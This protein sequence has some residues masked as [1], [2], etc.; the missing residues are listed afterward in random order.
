MNFWLSGGLMKRLV[1][2]K[3][4]LMTIFI[5]F[6]FII[7]IVTFKWLGLDFLPNFLFIDFLIVLMLSSVALLFKSNRLSK[8]YLTLL[9]LVFLVIS[10]TNQ[11]MKIELNG[12]IF[13]LSH[14]KYVDEATNVFLIEFIH[15]DALTVLI[16]I[17][18]VYGITIH[19]VSKLFFRSYL[20]EKQYYKQAVTYFSLIL[21]LF[22]TFFNVGI[23]SFNDYG[24]IFNI[25]LFKRETI[26]EYGLIGFYY[27]DVDILV[28]N[29]GIDKYN[30]E[31]LE[32]SLVYQ[33]GDFYGDSNLEISYNGLLEGKNVITIMVESGQSFAINEFLTPTLYKM[34]TQ[35]LFFPNHYSENKTNVSEVIG[36]LG[37]YPS[38]GI[39]PNRYDYDFQYSLPNILKE[40]GYH[41]AYFH[42][43]V[44]SFYDR[45]DMMPA[46]GFDDVYLHDTL[47]PDEPIYGWG[48]DYTLDSRTM[49][50][51]FDFM[52]DDDEPFYYFWSTLVGH[53]P[54][55]LN[56]P[57]SRG[58]NNLRKFEN[59]GYFTMIDLAESRGDWTNLMKDS[60]NELD[61]GRYKFYQATM[62]DFDRAMGKLLNQ[63]EDNDLLEDTVI[64]IYGDHSL[65]YHQMN[66]RLNDV[67]KG[68]IH[69]TEMYKTMFMVYNPILTSAYLTN[70]NTT[71]TT[72][73]KLV[74][75]YDILPT[76]FHLLGLPHYKNFVL[77]ESVLS[78]ESTIFYSHKMSA[79]FNE[80]YFSFN[81]YSIFYPEDILINEDLDA[82]NFVLKTRDL[83]E[84]ILWLEL[85]TELSKTKK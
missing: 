43:N 35:G 80:D 82:L 56:Y 27:K 60:E 31:E 25:N 22:F 13:S 51:M 74:T 83:S 11:T 2:E 19:Y 17:A 8:T 46:L 75:P 65:Y 72:I 42:E 49:D 16:S 69:H 15:F 41:T 64:I 37:S 59:L 14:F 61:P 28:F 36:V 40:S 52:F 26:E 70:N 38:E 79:F 24:K 10:F 44:G 1:L 20:Y 4:T 6:Y 9:L 18:L 47:F 62:M 66:L 81:N 57:S 71:S 85:W 77:G 53:G 12:E 23:S 68:E 29:S 50:R 48:G 7:E 78:D 34:S 39:E 21:L 54:Y 84:R 76:Y 73:E 55:N 32:E 63:L 30:I 3:L 58:I 45:D 33:N 67:E 5:I